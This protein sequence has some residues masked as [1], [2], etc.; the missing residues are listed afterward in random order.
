M[1]ATCAQNTKAYKGI[2]MLLRH[3]NRLSA[4]LRNSVVWALSNTSDKCTAI[5]GPLFFTGYRQT[6]LIKAYK[7]KGF[8]SA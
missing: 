8:A 6:F 1:S 5:Q 7:V 2:A 3:C 4:A